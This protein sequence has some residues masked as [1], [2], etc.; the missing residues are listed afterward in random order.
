MYIWFLNVYIYV[1]FLN[2]YICMV[3]E[4]I[5]VLFRN[6]YV[7]MVPEYIYIYVWFLNVYVW[8]NIEP[9]NSLPLVRMIC[10]D[11]INQSK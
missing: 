8:E 1:W 3:P 5:Y 7:C 10:L 11:I 2:V 9:E 6:I 4:C